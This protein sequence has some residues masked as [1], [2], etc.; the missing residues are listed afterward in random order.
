[1]AGIPAQ[2][3][4]NIITGD[5]FDMPLKVEQQQE[6]GSYLPID[7]T[8]YTVH[9]ILAPNLDDGTTPT[10]ENI[11][12]VHTDPTNGETMG[13]FTNAETAPLTPG[14]QYLIF[15]WIDT[16]SKRKTLAYFRVTIEEIGKEL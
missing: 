13:T 4:E 7:I 6:D 1:M 2:Y 5:D 15:K 14:E 8:G 10:L 16:S 11:V 3:G 12:T 9:F